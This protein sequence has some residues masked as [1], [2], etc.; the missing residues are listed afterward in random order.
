MSFLRPSRVKQ[1]TSGYGFFLAVVAAIAL[2]T[3]GF[4]QAG[5]RPQR[6]RARLDGFD[7]APKSANSPNQIAGAS[8]GL[9][10]ELYAPREGKSYT[11]N[12]TLTWAAV[13][14]K[15]VY[16][17]QVA[18]VRDPQTSLVAQKVT[19]GSFTYPADAPAL[20]PGMVYLFKVKAD[21]DMLGGASSTRIMIVGGKEREE[22]TAALATAATNSDPE[23]ARARV[24]TEKRLWYDAVDAFTKLIA[25]HP[26]RPELYQARADIYDQLPQTK[27]LADADADHAHP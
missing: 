5:Q 25:Q 3:G 27:A 14:S 21:N 15:A 19:G 22:I 11:T 1:A 12:P 9:D 2:V 8:R 6:V 13:D 10:P 26:D 18:S 20:E 16:Q 24:Y 4:A 23:L 7:V 17:V